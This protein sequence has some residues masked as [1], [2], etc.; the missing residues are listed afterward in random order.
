MLI[1]LDKHELTM[2]DEAL[3]L[4]ADEVVK[5][6]NVAVFKPF[7]RGEIFNLMNYLRDEDM[8]DDE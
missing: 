6:D 3:D 8:E 4:L 2:I 7:T 5:N 1:N